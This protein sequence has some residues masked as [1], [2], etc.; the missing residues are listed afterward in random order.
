MP[1][2]DTTDRD[3][4]LA[5]LVQR[6]GTP[7]GNAVIDQKATPTVMKVN[8]VDVP[9][10]V[11]DPAYIYTWPDGTT[12]SVNGAGQVFSLDER[13]PD[14]TRQ[15]AWTNIRNVG[16]TVY[17]TDPA[18]G[19]FK[20]IPG[21]PPDAATKG[22]TNMVAIPQPDGTRTYW[23]TDP[24]DG[25]FKAV[26]GS[27]TLPADQ[28]THPNVQGQDG[29]TYQWDDTQ[30]KYVPAP[31]IP[32]GQARPTEG[33]TRQAIENGR[34]VT[35]TFSGGQW[36]TTSVGANAVPGAPQEGQTR[37]T[38][39]NGR[40]VTQTYQG[41]QWTT[42]SVGGTAIPGAPQEG[43]QRSAVENGRNVTQ[44]YSGGQWVT[45]GVGDSAVPGAPKE[46]DTRKNVQ[47]GYTVQEVYK[48]GQWVVDPSV[49]PVRFTPTTPTAINASPTD[50]NITT[51]TDGQINSQ[52]NPNFIAKT[53]AD[54]AAR[55]GQLQQ[56][57][58]AKRDDLSRQVAGGSLS[59]DQAAQQFDQWWA[60]NIEPQKTS[61]QA[62]QQQATLDQQQKQQ[63][64]QRANLATAQEAGRTAVQAYQTMMPNMV[65]PGF[66][67]M[68]NQLAQGWASGKVPQNLDLGSALT[69]QGPDLNQLA[70]Q[71]TSQALAHISPTAAQN[72]NQATGPGVPNYAPGTLQSGPPPQD[73][74]QMLNASNYRPGST[75]TIAPDG[76]VTINH[77][78]PA[79]TPPLPTPPPAPA[80]PSF[81][82][83]TYQPSTYGVLS[84][85]MPSLLTPQ[86]ALQPYQLA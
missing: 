44:T 67:T 86:P 8:G 56:A 33:Q 78:T 47:S 41:G 73:M 6:H 9:Q 7:Y 19:Q 13:K 69:Y 45:T 11:D 50:L 66:G 21:V 52:P 34:N 24:A 57:A 28:K 83:A 71:V 54:V 62:A 72:M 18:D 77:Q 82:P 42:T 36:V 75:T 2:T 17:G 65:G 49:A 84:G 80:A 12:V 31:G 37:Q 59:Q 53:Q 63:E 20:A 48:G 27:P 58:L 74:S 29:T 1:V 46:G 35:Q 25:Q 64:Q 3:Q 5:Q 61:L 85:Q 15:T 38:I 4:V 51:M 26:P 14:T 22:F 43:Q 39:E 76:T 23:G 70:Q 10:T 16:N 30:N 55:T 40:N 79:P 60:Q 32:Q 68:M 81:T